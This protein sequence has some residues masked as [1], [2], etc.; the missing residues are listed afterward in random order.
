M[1]KSLGFDK[2]R[3]ILLEKDWEERDVL[4]QKLDELDG[5]LNERE[6]LETRV[7]PIIED[8]QNKLQQNFPVL[9]G[10]QI[11]ESI[12]RQIK[13]S[14]E[15]VIEVLYPIIGRMIK[16]YITTE[17]E[18]LNER[19]DQ[20]MDLAMSAKGWKLRFKSWRTGTPMKDLIKAEMLEPKIESI[21]VIER[22]SGLL[23][24]SFAKEETIDKDMLAGM[25]TAIKAFVEDAFGKEKQELESIDYE[26]YKV[27]LKNFKSFYIAVVTSGGS[28]VTFRH[29][30]DDQLLSFASK[31]LSKAHTPQEDSDREMITSGLEEYFNDFDHVDD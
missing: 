26:N 7:S 22:A 3:E 10:P 29:K 1:S 4:A 12:R 14:Q 5:Q 15:E 13:E 25:L 2:L 6:Q 11:T 27:I 18:M 23:I 9:F 24:A 20:Q 28:T 30:L 19:V 31:V 17:I 21:Y 8:Q 16:K